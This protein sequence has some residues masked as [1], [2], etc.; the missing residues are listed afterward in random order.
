MRN[1]L[2]PAL[3][4]LGAA[5]MSA[6]H[7]SPDEALAR[8]ASAPGM[9]KAA[10]AS[11]APRLVRSVAAE[12]IE[13]V[14]VYG[15]PSGRGFMVVSADDA[16]PAI[17]AYSDENALPAGDLPANLAAW[18][19][20]YAAQIAVIAETG[21]APAP[22]IKARPEVAP[23]LTTLWDQTEPF[24]SYTPTHNGRPCPTGCVATAMAQV[25]NWHKWPLQPH[26]SVTF[27]SHYIGQLQMDFERV[28]LAW[29]KMLDRYY[30]S[31]PQENIDAVAMLMIA[32]GYGAEMTYHSSSSG[33]TGYGGASAFFKYFGYSKAL[34]LERREWYD[35]D[36][37]DDLV[38]AELTENG[39]VYYEGTGNGGGHAFVCDGY[40][41]ETGLFHF[42][43]GWT[44]RGNGY[45]RLSLLNPDMQGV[46]G[47]SLGYNYTQDIIRG[48]KPVK[49][50][51]DEEYARVFSPGMGVITPFD[52]CTLG[53]L[54]TIKGYDTTDGFC[55]YSLI[56]LPQVTFGVRI[57]NAANGQV[58]DVTADNAPYDF[59][60]YT[61]V[62]I[63]RFALPTDLAEGD[64]SLQPLWRSG[65]EKKWNEMRYCTWTRNYVPFSVAGKT[66]T[67]GF[68]DA[69]G[70]AEGVITSVPDFFTTYGDFEVKA[71]LDCPG[72][73]DFTGLLCGV[74]FRYDS[75]GEL[76][77]IDQGEAVR[78]DIYKG[79]KIEFEYNSKPQNGKLTDGD[80]YGF[81]LGNA[82]TGEVVTPIYAVKVGNRY[83]RLQMSAYNFSLKNSNFLD[84]ESVN[85]STNIKVI[86]GEYHGPLALGFSLERDPFEPIR[87]V[88]SGNVDIIAGEDKNFSIDGNLT[89]VTAG[90]LY[91]VHLLYKDPDDQW[92][93]LSTYPITTVIA[94]TSGIADVISTPEV[95][96]TY[97]DVYGRKIDTPVKGGI[98]VRV[99]ADGQRTKVIY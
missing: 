27:N 40:E 61:K 13:Q 29:D 78:V 41:A 63:I 30:T 47:N 60:P 46:G 75:K 2:L 87:I 82:S 45:Y 35:I 7:L 81:A 92:K 62:N 79:Q 14:Y 97:Y 88:E 53:D 89:D 15:D 72:T 85:G 9:R 42:N 54:I 58:I 24:N 5:S 83:G 23:K 71:T 6:R 26:G 20:Y 28:T 80:D 48:L 12:G 86:S 25:M 11:A 55:N 10:P 32:C 18:L 34:S 19:D 38:Y 96:D 57:R 90:D 31:S 37:W 50:A 66:A 51:V 76:Q 59:A 44:G 67:F 98:Y 21:A 93:E 39:P 17:L 70:R 84:P 43:W 69:E 68:G 99:S 4:L 95:A 52:S 49:E 65:A 16:A 1:I 74:F 64:Y 33:A 73:H 91:Y 3:V 94:K 77:V 22:K 36:E 8:A 56:N